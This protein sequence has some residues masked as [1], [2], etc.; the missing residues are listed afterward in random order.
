MNDALPEL[1]KG[2]VLVKTDGDGE[3]STLTVIKVG[4]GKEFYEPVYYLQGLYGVKIRQPYTGEALAALGYRLK[5]QAVVVNTTTNG[6]V[7]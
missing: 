7:R 3:V 2:D 1:R 4:Q 6:G 5:N